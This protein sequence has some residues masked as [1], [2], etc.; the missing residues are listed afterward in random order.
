M[1]V[2]EKFYVSTII[3]YSYKSDLCSKYQDRFMKY[4]E[5]LFIF[6]KHDGI[7]WHNNPAENALRAITLQL[8]IS[9]VLHKSVIKEY[10]ILLGIK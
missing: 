4:R 3:D 2:I 8:D 10:L 9:G 5:S 1:R 7:P 6:L